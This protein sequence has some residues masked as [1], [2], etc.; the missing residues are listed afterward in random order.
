MPKKRPRSKTK[1]RRKHSTRTKRS[2][3][4]IALLLCLGFSIPLAIYA[5]VLDRIVVSKFE[6]K[7]FS[8]PAKVYARPLELYEGKTLNP[9]QLHHELQLLNYRKVLNIQHP[10]EYAQ[11]GNQFD[12]YTRPFTFWDGEQESQVLSLNLQN[13]EIENLIQE[14]SGQ[15]LALARLEPFA[16]GG[17][18]PNKGEDRVLVRLEQVPQHLINALIATED[19]RFY[20]HHGVDPKSLLRALSTIFTKERMHGG[21]TLTQQLVKN[22][23]LTQERTI[24]RKLKEMVMAISLELHYSKEDILETYINEVYFGQDRN[25]AIHGFALASEFYFSRNIEHLDIHQSALLVGLLKGPAYYNPRR[26][27]QRATERRNLVLAA[28][29]SESFINADTYAASRAQSLGVA[30]LP[31]RGQSLYP[32]FMGLVMQQL[33]R[34]Y[35]ES[36]L[37]SEGLRIFTSLDPFIQAAAENNLSK[38]LDSLEHQKKLNAGTLEGAVVIANVPDGEVS[39]VV[40]GRRP[41]YQGFNRALDARRQ[42]GSLIKPAI[43]LT[44]LMQYDNFHLASPL[45]DSPFTWEEDGIEPWQPQ[46]YDRE[47]HGNVPL[48]RA[49]AK[50]YNV[51]AARLGTELGV[52]KVMRTVNALGVEQELPSYASGLL[53]TI[54]MSPIEVAQMYHTF[55]S[56]GFRTPF[57]AI[58]EVT[59]MHG[60]PLNRYDLATT[61]VIPSNANYLIN[62]ALERVITHGTGSGATRYLPAN[63]RVAGKT[64]TTD[65]LRDSWFAGY[66]GDKVA[67]VWVGNDDNLTTKLTGASGALSIWRL[68]MA[69][70]PLRPINMSQPDDIVW[71]SVDEETGFLANNGCRNTFELPFHQASLPANVLHCDK[72]PK[73]KIKRWFKKILGG[74]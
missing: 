13:E 8:I 39:A 1:P 37:R 15:A 59:T 67:V 7:R 52:A 46:N 49:L 34:D 56:G 5:V 64:G 44:A 51:S 48:W 54:H 45:D 60:E 57:R 16:M 22:F 11:S 24:S 25:R 17:I 9:E 71:A 61:P 58:R 73:G 23:Y 62:H 43:Y 29:Q 26:H 63:L 14:D 4:K 2:Y 35:K 27:P 74:D 20:S 32:A 38:R 41:K 69:D 50:S 19:R 31:D 66:S 18:Y 70:I 28:M 30:P 72:K 55:A 53:G 33:T 10:G 47:F 21:S 3:F 65:N 36:D 6:G 12:I 40:G 68:I 42:I